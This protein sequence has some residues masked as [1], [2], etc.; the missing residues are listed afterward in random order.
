M[1]QS[2]TPSLPSFEGWVI[3][4]EGE[5]RLKGIFKVCGLLNGHPSMLEEEEA[6]EGLENKLERRLSTE[7]HEG[8]QAV[9]ADLCARGAS[10][11][12]KPSLEN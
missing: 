2:V 3:Y 10:A 6:A 11:G 7:T 12:W 1:L 4:R 5:R 9:G 8:R